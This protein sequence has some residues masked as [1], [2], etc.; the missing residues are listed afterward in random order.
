MSEGQRQTTRDIEMEKLITH[1]S[2]RKSTARLKGPH[3]EVKAE[4]RQREA[5][6]WGHTFIR[7]YGWSVVGFPG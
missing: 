6:P 2:W 1:R 4:C 5:G 3:G 7:V